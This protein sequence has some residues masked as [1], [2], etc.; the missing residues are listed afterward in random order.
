M[1][2]LNDFKE[3]SGW[4]MRMTDAQFEDMWAGISEGDK[5]QTP[6][7]EGLVD[8]IKGSFSSNMVALKDYD[9]LQ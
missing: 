5:V 3:D 1:G 6:F 4:D 2:L 7:I 8:Q 9:I